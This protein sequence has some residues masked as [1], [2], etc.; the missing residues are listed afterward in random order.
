MSWLERSPIQGIIN[1]LKPLP[2]PETDC[3]GKTIIVTGAN[4]GLGLEAARHFVRLNAAKVI[5]GCR[6]VEKGSQAKTDIE[7]STNRTGVAEVWQLDLTSFD[8]VKEFCQRAE[9]LHRL[10]VVVENAGVATGDFVQYEGYEQQI[11]VNVISTFLMALL[12][13]PS[14]RRTATRFNVVPSLV[15]VTS[16]AHAYTSLTRARN[17]PSIFE[18]LRGSAGMSG[19][20]S[21]SKLLEVLVVRELATE[22]ESSPKKPRVALNLV[23]PGL[24]KS[25]LFRHITWPISWIIAIGF[26]LLARTSEMGSRTLVSAALA[27][28]ETHGKYLGDCRMMEP[29]RFVR[30]EEGKRVQKRAYDELLGILE[31]VEPG[32]TKNI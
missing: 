30:S 2:Y 14:L 21:N 18:A 23:H 20:Y 10:D 11:T 22:M 32:I 3:S 13:L 24:C 29:S 16:D 19:R 12:I 26:L 25:K 1:Q 28:E 9:K 8:S 17:A 5:L 7:T 6:N 15:I 27:G 31:G 4:V